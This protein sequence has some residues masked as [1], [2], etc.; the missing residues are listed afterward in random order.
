MIALNLAV[1]NIF[2][3][4]QQRLHI[5]RFHCSVRIYVVSCFSL[6]SSFGEEEERLNFF[7][8]FPLPLAGQR[9]VLA[10][11]TTREYGMMLCVCVGGCVGV[12]VG[13]L[14]A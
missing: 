11:R 4:D 10:E 14:T 12:G 3:A 8:L 1:R 9:L 2:P 13:V 7:S 6:L 5:S